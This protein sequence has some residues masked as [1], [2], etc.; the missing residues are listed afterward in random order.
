M[1][2]HGK[3]IHSKAKSIEKKFGEGTEDLSR[4]HYFDGVL[5]S[6]AAL[7]CEPVAAAVAWLVSASAISPPTWNKCQVTPNT[8]VKEL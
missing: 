4:P 7:S 6:L 5:I 3:K 1:T 2:V 8:D